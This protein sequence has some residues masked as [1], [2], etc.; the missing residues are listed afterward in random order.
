MTREFRTKD[1]APYHRILSKGTWDKAYIAPHLQKHEVKPSGIQAKP[2][3]V[4][5]EERVLGILQGEL[6]P[7][8]PEQTRGGL[9]FRV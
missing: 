3:E 2:S 4:L 8:P 9:G 5:R 6:H 7:R 1:P